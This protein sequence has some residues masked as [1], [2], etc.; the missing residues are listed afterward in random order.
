[1]GDEN[2]MVS[3]MQEWVLGSVK[4]LKT[5][6]ESEVKI[7]FHPLVKRLHPTP[8]LC[9]WPVDLAKQWIEDNEGYDRELYGGV[10]QVQRGEEE[11]AIVL[12]RCMKFELDEAFA[13]V[14]G[15]IMKDSEPNIEW[16]ETLWK[17]KSFTFAADENLR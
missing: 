14:G 17:L 11:W 10:V 3:P 9:G 6:I 2:R 12:L 16:K 8:A 15:G 4:H 13:F 1:M 5:T 7:P